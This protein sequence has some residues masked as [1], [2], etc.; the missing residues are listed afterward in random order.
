MDPYLE[1]HWG[2]VHTRLTVYASN[3]LNAQLPDDL[4]ARVEEDVT[5]TADGERTRAVYPDVGVIEEPGTGRV[6]SGE[7]SMGV[8]MA[9][10]IVVTVED[11][12]RT[13]RHIEIID[14][15]DGGRVVTAIEF[16]SPANKVGSTGQLIYIR[17]QRHY[18]D[19]GVNLVEIDLIRAGN[20]VLAIPEDR[21]PPAC[22]TPYLACIRR[23]TRPNQAELYPIPLRQP[24]P[25][26]PVPLRPTDKDVVL[27][28]QPLLDDCYRDGRY[29]RLNYGPDPTPRLG[30]SDARWADSILKDK[31]LR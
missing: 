4:Q 29:G 25:N 7:A 17:K 26:L 18:L 5:V 13:L 15:R 12:P 6:E 28:L 11:E 9:E 1:A 31:G 3:Q 22:R 10:P 23:A 21:L 27:R 2:D 20:Y 16:L 30:E 24:L 8:A 19:A 14:T